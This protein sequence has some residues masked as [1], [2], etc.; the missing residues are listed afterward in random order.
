M[1]NAQRRVVVSNRVIELTLFA[2]DYI[3]PWKCSQ[4][5]FGAALRQ[6]RKPVITR[7]RKRYDSGS[8][9]LLRSNRIECL[10]REPKAVRTNTRG[11]N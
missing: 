9:Y 10:R 2:I 3:T 11:E 5:P 6:K 7:M 4:F 8:F 1:T